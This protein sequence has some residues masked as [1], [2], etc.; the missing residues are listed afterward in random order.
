VHISRVVVGAP[1]FDSSAGR[2]YL[3]EK[4]NQVWQL[5][6]TFDGESKDDSFG[7]S[8]QLSTDVS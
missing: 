8:A 4:S 6:A 5:N 7:V 2:V 3:Y 1:G